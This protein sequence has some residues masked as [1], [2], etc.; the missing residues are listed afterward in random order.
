M[1]SK[2]PFRSLLYGGV[3]SA[4]AEAVTVPLDVLKVR[5]QLQGESGGARQYRN[6]LDA[7][8]QIASKEGPLAFTKGL[9]PAVLR[10]LTYGSLR[11]GLYVPCKSF[12]GVRQQGES[13]PLARMAAGATAGGTAAL[14]CTPT[15]LIK[16]R[17][18]ADGLRRSGPPS[19][20]GVTHAFRSI[21]QQ[22][23][24]LA[25]YTGASPTMARAAVVA[26]AEIASYDEIKCL[27]LRRRW[28]NDGIVL[29][30][31]TAML[32]GFLATVASSPFDVIKSRV[33][34]QP[35]DAQ[36]KGILYTSVSDC[37]V[38][39]WRA[40][41]LS[42]AYRGFWPNYLNKGP[43]VVLLFL[44]Y[45]QFRKVGDRWLDDWS[46]KHNDGADSLPSEGRVQRR[47]SCAFPA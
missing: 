34:S 44:L 25:L 40:E 32:S 5:M 24:V 42:F 45:E 28:M 14:V 13:A 31:S 7:A 46:A 41:G 43:T 47:A 10:Q 19:Y 22:E 20:N 6:T 1:D 29:Q 4:V 27:F 9:K 38:K 8:V 11:F 35:V 17:M 37:L 39:S 33:M 15:D 30:L 3:S 16:V 2:S 21:M 12:Y 18:Q 23:G 26:A 36:G